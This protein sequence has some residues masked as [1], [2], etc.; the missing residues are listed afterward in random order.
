MHSLTR[1]VQAMKWNWAFWRFVP[2]RDFK[3]IVIR[4]YKKL[5]GYHEG[6]RKWVEQGPEEHVA[7][8]H[9]FTAIPKALGRR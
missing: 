5:W 4:R 9:A 3:V 1:G 7:G 2:W 6:Q 8:R